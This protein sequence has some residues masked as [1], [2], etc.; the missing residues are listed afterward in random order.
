MLKAIKFHLN[1]IDKFHHSPVLG[2]QGK[3]KQSSCVGG[4][5]TIFIFLLLIYVFGYELNTIAHYIDYYH[6]QIETAVDMKNLGLLSLEEMDTMPYFS[7]HYIGKRLK[8][9]KDMENCAET[10]GDC[11]TL[12]NNYFKI[13]WDNAR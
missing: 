4:T 10:E 7:I 13:T 9:T 11:M 3:A 1:K 8:R 6:R 2:F 5:A 12:V